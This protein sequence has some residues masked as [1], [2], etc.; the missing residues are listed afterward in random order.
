MLRQHSSITKG[1]NG[2][3]SLLTGKSCHSLPK[4]HSSFPLKMERV[5]LTALRLISGSKGMHAIWI[6]ARARV[7][8]CNHTPAGMH[9]LGDVSWAAA[10]TELCLCSNTECEQLVD[11]RRG[12]NPAERHQ[13]ETGRRIWG[14]YYGACLQT[15]AHAAQNRF[16]S[17]RSTSF[18]NPSHFYIV[19][20]SS[21]RSI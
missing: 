20:V 8:V 9:R 14:G 17:L 5:L 15:A 13:G 19:L 4:R 21:P 11:G 3:V 10:A 2:T 12:G 16:N 6:C 1:G 18:L 7:C